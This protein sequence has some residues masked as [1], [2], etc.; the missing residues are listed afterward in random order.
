[1]SEEY[2][3]WPNWETWLISL[4]F[5]DIIREEIDI[6]KESNT[7]NDFQMADNLRD[8]LEEYVIADNKPD[9][10]FMSSLINKFLGK[11][12]WERIVKSFSE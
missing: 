6:N 9:T 12:D 11:V 7:Y 5:G 10:L 1:M 2:K 8:M 4:H 3:D